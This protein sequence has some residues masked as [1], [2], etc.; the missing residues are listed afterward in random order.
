MQNAPEPLVRT[1]PPA[2][3][4]L[5][6]LYSPL[7]AQFTVQQFEDPVPAPKTGLRSWIRRVAEAMPAVP[8]FKAVN[9]QI[10]Q[11]DSLDLSYRPFALVDYP[12]AVLRS[13][14]LFYRAWG[15][16]DILQTLPTPP[17]QQARP[18]KRYARGAGLCGRTGVPGRPF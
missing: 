6:T 7:C 17:A 13:H 16:P 8:S 11:V 2:R 1:P 15:L 14:G 12:E 18:E 9:Q 10:S 3:R 5:R 4:R